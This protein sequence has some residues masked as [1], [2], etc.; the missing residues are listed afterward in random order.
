MNQGTP[1]RKKHLQ[2]LLY[3]A[4]KLAKMQYY[5]SFVQFS[6]Q[7]TRKPCVLSRAKAIVYSLQVFV[8]NYTWKIWLQMHLPMVKIH[9][10]LR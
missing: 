10:Q 8:S 4:E 5:I 6:R 7:N 9:D 3:H 1:S 2:K